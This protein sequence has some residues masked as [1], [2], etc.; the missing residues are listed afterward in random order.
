MWWCWEWWRDVWHTRSTKCWE[1][2]NVRGGIVQRSTSLELSIMEYQSLWVLITSQFTCPGTAQ[3]SNISPSLS[4]SSPCCLIS[5]TITISIS[6]TYL[7]PLC[8]ALV[9]RLV[10][11]HA[12]A[13][14]CCCCCCPRWLPPPPPRCSTLLRARPSTR[15][16]LINTK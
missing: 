14:W 2:N 12:C 15:T 5:N 11:G 10:G 7:F 9:L 6:F 4:L 13:S 3:T 8:R 1:D 16:N